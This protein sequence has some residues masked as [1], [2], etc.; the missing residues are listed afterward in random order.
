[1]ANSSYTL[2]RLFFFVLI[3]T[4][5]RAVTLYFNNPNLNIDE[6]Y[7]WVWSQNF[8]WGYYSKP[9]VVA[10]L[11]STMSNFF[12]DSSI[13]IKSISLI[14]YPITAGV[15]YLTAKELFDQKTAFYAGLIFLTMPAVSL[16]SHI[17]S[18]DVPLFLF[19]SLT[20]YAFVL[21]FKYNKTSF[22]VFAGFFGGL[23]LLS[24]YNM[25]VFPL[26]A[27][28]YLIYS[29]DNR[30][31]LSNSNIYLAI[32]IALI[33]FL[34][35]LAWNYQN[36]FISFTHLR[37]IS[38]VDRD[39][40]HPDQLLKFV[41]DQFG[42]FGIISFAVLLYGFITVFKHRKDDRYVL[43]VM[44]SLVFLLIIFAQAFMSRAFANWAAPAYVTG[45][46]LVAYILAKYN[47]VWLFRLAIILNMTLAVVIYHYDFITQTFD[48]ELSKSNDPFKKI[49]GWDDFGKQVSVIKRDFP[50]HTLLADHRGVL[51]EVIYYTQPH[52]FDAQIYN[53]NRRMQNFYDQTQDLNQHI[54]EHFLYLTES[55]SADAISQYFDNAKFIQMINIQIHSDYAIR[56]SVFEL[57]NFKGY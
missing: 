27:L 37:E 1:M 43:L 8:D 31:Y 28:L 4:T 40:F 2:N 53:P 16:S 41:G 17:I 19:W 25:I 50:N 44:F 11:I 54:G 35:N 15:V 10:W 51:S 26:S 9:P 34:P 55:N 52:E 48:I 47:K 42:V 12:G 45:S 36:D 7:Y 29:K 21:A 39:L 38:Q 32:V 6:A 56:Y 22:W 30:K 24:K 57:N 5:Y 18:T 14:L 33:V 13:A 23:G 49:R 20:F 46:I 3:L